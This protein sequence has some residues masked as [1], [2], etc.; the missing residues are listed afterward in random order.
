MALQF[1]TQQEAAAQ[2]NA[3]EKLTNKKL[4]AIAENKAHEVL[5]NAAKV[6]AL[7]ATN[8]KNAIAVTKRAIHDLEHAQDVLHEADH[9][10]QTANNVFINAQTETAQAAQNA[11][12]ALSLNLNARNVYNLAFGELTDKKQL[13]QEALD[14]KAKADIVVANA[15]N[16]LTI[17]NQA[18]DDA[19]SALTTAQRNYEIAYSALD[20]ANK[21]VSKVRA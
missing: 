12:A 17:V 4:A 5:E 15:K 10:L 9:A 21:L 13:L 8:V 19:L 14:R 7:H 1:A 11:K 18:N 20:N 3:A 16:C 2:A 6:V